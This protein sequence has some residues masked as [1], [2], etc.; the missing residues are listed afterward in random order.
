MVSLQTSIAQFLTKKQLERS[1]SVESCKNSDTA[2]TEKPTASV[3]PVQNR[4]LMDQSSSQTELENQPS[5][6]K[7]KNS[8]MNDCSVPNGPLVSNCDSKVNNGHLDVSKGA[9]SLLNPSCSSLNGDIEMAEPARSKSDCS[10]TT[11][12]G[13]TNLVKLTWPSGDKHVTV[14]SIAQTSGGRNIVINTVSKTNNVYTRVVPGVPGKLAG[15]TSILSTRGSNQ[16]GKQ[17]STILKSNIAS[18]S[19]STKV[20]TVNQSQQG[21]RN[22]FLS[23]FY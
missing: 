6:I 4:D 11:P 1:N 16:A 8:N 17:G 22:K 14:S 21:K 23:Q 9:V 20:I 2:K 19:S 12:D 15:Q 18:G 7:S 5:D 13:T 3:Q 10:S